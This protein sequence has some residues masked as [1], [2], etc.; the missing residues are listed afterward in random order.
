VSALHHVT[1]DQPGDRAR[2][3]TVLVSY[4]SSTSSTRFISRHRWARAGVADALSG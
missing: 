2:I 1:L 3:A 4:G